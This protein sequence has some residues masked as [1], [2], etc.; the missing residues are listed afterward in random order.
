MTHHEIEQKDIIER[1]VRHQ[2]SGAERRAFQ[3]HY[4]ACD[5]CFANVNS[6]AKFIAGVQRSSRVG[7]LSEVASKAAAPAWWAAWFKPAFGLAATACILLA[8]ALG[9]I[10]FRQIPQLRNEIAQERQ[11]RETAEQRAGQS[12]QATQ[13]EVER[14]RQRAET[15]KK[16]REELEAQIALN[17]LPSPTP[18]TASP[19]PS[20][21]VSPAPSRPNNETK[22]NV[23]VVILESTRDSKSG[24]NFKLPEDATALT[25]WIEGEAGHPFSSYQMQILQGGTVIKTVSGLKANSYGAL[26]ASVSTKQLTAGK[27][28]V[29]L[30]GIKDQQKEL[31]GEYDLTLR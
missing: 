5:E 1:Y 12:Q 21:S 10:V 3:E 19:M 17:K 11:A 18:I 27:Y 30:F 15:E 16:K 4:F 31:V 23:P 7:A 28:V 8:L 26:T 13:E 9:W 6:T 20:T 14:E 2:L 24:T 22:A 29:K 25:L